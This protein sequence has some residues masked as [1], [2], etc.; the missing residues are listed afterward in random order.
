MNEYRQQ[1]LDLCIETKLRILNNRTRGD[2]QGHLTY[3]GFHGCSAV[4]LVLTSEASLTKSTIVQYLSV[5]DLNFLSDHRPILLKLTRNYNF[6]PNKIIKD[7]QVCELKH[8]PT[9]YTWKNSL[10][11]DFALR[12]SLETNKISI[13]PLGN[14]S[15]TDFRSEI[16]VTLGEI[17]TAF[18][19]GA[20]GVL[21]RKI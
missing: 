18:I 6:L 15:D 21:R 2:L 20:E 13:V 5:Q 8:K 12:L 19:R 7:T 17:Q 16:E 10:G 3:V 9:R 11:K 4:D 1:P 14:E